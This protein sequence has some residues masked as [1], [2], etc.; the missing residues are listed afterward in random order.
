MASGVG[1]AANCFR[2]AQ[3]VSDLVH[4]VKPLLARDLVVVAAASGLT[5]S[6]AGTAFRT[7]RDDNFRFQRAGTLALK[8]GLELIVSGQGEGFE[9][10]VVILLTDA[11]QRRAPSGRLAAV[12]A[13]AGQR[14]RDWPATLRAAVAN[15]LLRASDLLLIQLEVLPTQADRLTRA[16]AGVAD[17]LLRVARAIH[18]HTLEEI[19]QADRGMDADNHY[20]AL[21]ETL[22]RREGIFPIDGMSPFLVVNLTSLQT[23]SDAFAGCTALLL[24][25][26][27]AGDGV[28]WQNYGAVYCALK[29]SQRDAL[30]AGFRY[31]YETSASFAPDIAGRLGGGATIPVVDDL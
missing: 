27:L 15:A 29:P 14:L 13:E 22:A 1:M 2:T 9:L 25:N 12:W 17:P 11:L 28:H 16:T 5:L 3:A 8:G 18:R 21:I 19:A 24:L 26:N 7:L 23:H 4:H 10:A 6:Q 20:M 31:V 30:L